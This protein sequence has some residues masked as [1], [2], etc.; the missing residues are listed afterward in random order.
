MDNWS[1]TGEMITDGTMVTIPPGVLRE[2]APYVLVVS[3]ASNIPMASP[4]QI[5]GPA[6]AYAGTVSGLLMP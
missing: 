4:Y 6:N 1:T 3:G 2:G 5:V